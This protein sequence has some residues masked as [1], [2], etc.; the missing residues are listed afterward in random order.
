[1]YNKITKS[2]LALGAVLAFCFVGT[3]K[4]EQLPKV[5]PDQQSKNL[6]T[7]IASMVIK[8]PDVVGIDETTLRIELA[9]APEPNTKKYVA[10]STSGHE[11]AEFKLDEE[12]GDVEPDLVCFEGKVRTVTIKTK[13]NPRP[14][15]SYNSEVFYPL[16]ISDNMPPSANKN[17]VIIKHHDLPP[18]ITPTIRVWYP[19]VK[20]VRINGNAGILKFP[21]NTP[22]RIYPDCVFANTSR[23]KLQVVLAQKV[24]VDVEGQV[25]GGSN[26][27][28]FTSRTWRVS[29]G[30]MIS[31]PIE[32]STVNKP[33]YEWPV[34]RCNGEDNIGLVEQPYRAIMVFIE[35]YAKEGLGPWYK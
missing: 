35:P 26:S 33:S 9:V 17:I 28:H 30:E 20:A 4:S 27:I 25:I 11:V 6:P 15:G 31:A 5:T 7:L 8:D 18:R 21:G 23:N 19:K 24:G 34:I 32:F 2:L 12:K 10:L 16:G 22:R 13:H 1:M 14:N 3:S 29:K